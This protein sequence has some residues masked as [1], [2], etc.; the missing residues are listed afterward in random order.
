MDPRGRFALVTGAGSGI[1]RATA[2]KLAAQGAGVAL[3]DLDGQALSATAATIRQAGGHA[4]EIS[5]DVTSWDSLQAAF[6]RAESEFGGIDIVHNNAGIN[7]GRP[8]FPD[9]ELS[10]WERTLAVDLWAVIAG[11]Q[12]AVA[13]LRRRGGG[14]IVNTGSL[15]AVTSFPADPVYAAAKAGVVNLTRSLGFLISESIRVVCVC[16]GV[17][18]TPLLAKRELSDADE[19]VIRSIPLLEPPAVAD[20]VLDLVRDDSLSGAVVGLLPGRPPRLI[21][22]QLSF[23]DDP[24]L[25]MES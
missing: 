5:A 18:A 13:A 6:G 2:E 20:A 17:V 1:G 14:V 11:T 7:T 15:A 3:V 10:R 4:I 19:K 21:P 22:T 8:R 16:P 24:T 12:L 9:S 23:P 25:G